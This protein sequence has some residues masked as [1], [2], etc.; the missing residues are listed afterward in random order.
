MSYLLL[1]KIIFQGKQT[2]SYPGS[3]MTYLLLSKIFQGKKQ[4]ATPVQL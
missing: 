1:G 4:K 3:I 2:K